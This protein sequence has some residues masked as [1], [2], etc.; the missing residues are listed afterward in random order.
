[1]PLEIAY[2][3][4]LLIVTIH[5]DELALTGIRCVSFSS[6]KTFFELFRQS[7]IVTHKNVVNVLTPANVVRI[8]NDSFVTVS[9]SKS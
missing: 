5:G 6:H 8:P 1:M 3:F 7:I 9:A 2:I 4:N